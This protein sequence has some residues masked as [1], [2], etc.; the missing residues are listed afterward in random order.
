MNAQDMVESLSSDAYV[1]TFKKANGE[2]REMVCTLNRGIIGETVGRDGSVGPN[3]E[4]N[5]AEL[6][7]VFDL[8]KCGWRRFRT[9]SVESFDKWV[10]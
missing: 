9:D 2:M 8:R 10:D 6:L 5:D 7:T 1:V 3:P 4:N